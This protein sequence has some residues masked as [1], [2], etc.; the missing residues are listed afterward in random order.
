M[1]ERLNGAWLMMNARAGPRGTSGLVDT[2]GNPGDPRHQLATEGSRWR[3]REEKGRWAGATRTRQAHAQRCAPAPP[4]SLA[5]PATAAMY[6]IRA[7][8]TDELVKISLSLCS[9][10]RFGCSS[11]R[12]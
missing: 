2:R 4:G 12:R 1:T 11:C 7:A 6:P 3:Q 10:I 5:S 8:G 9:I